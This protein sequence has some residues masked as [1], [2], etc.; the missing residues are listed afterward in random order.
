MYRTFPTLLQEQ[1]CCVVRQ[2]HM[3][4][5]TPFQYKLK[6]VSSVHVFTEKCCSRSSISSHKI[7]CL[8]KQN[9][10]TLACSQVGLNKGQVC[11][12][13]RNGQKWLRLETTNTRDFI[14]HRFPADK[15]REMRIRKKKSPKF[16]LFLKNNAQRSST[17]MLSFAFVEKLHA[18]NFISIHFDTLFARP[19]VAMQQF[20]WN[21]YMYR[22]FCVHWNRFQN[23]P[24]VLKCK[25]NVLFKLHKAICRLGRVLWQETECWSLMCC[26]FHCLFSVPAKLHFPRSRALSFPTLLFCC[27]I[28]DLLLCKQSLYT[29][30]LLRMF[31]H[32]NQAYFYKRTKTVRAR[33]QFWSVK[34]TLCGCFCVHIFCF[35]LFLICW[36][37][38]THL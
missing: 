15:I 33:V 27:F 17:K 35:K 14:W 21:G 31:T 11:C 1:K 10:S 25:K 26:H 37:C 23:V 32:Q 29:C 20:R 30:L 12:F 28:Y 6:R 8:L 38:C 7:C 24:R 36:S 22:M 5:L 16:R 18:C 3:Y 9:P 2:Q 13:V 34:A 19:W 4:K